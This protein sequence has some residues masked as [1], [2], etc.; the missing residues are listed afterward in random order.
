MRA[1]GYARISDEERA[2]EGY[3]M[4]S[5]H[6][7]ITAYCQAHG[8]ELT[9]IY[10]DGKS[11]KAVAG[12]DGLAALIEDAG[13]G[14]IDRVIVWKLDR[15]GRNLRD[16]LEI[17]DRLEASG[18]GL[19]SI[20][21]SIDTGTAA[22]RMMR[23]MLGVIAEFERDTIVDRIKA[24]LEQKARQ[25][26][27]LGH[28]PLGYQRN[29]AGAVVLDPAAA[30]L[31]RALFERY[32]IG[33]HSLRDLV[34]WCAS[35][36]LRSIFGNPL[37]RLAINKI[38]RNVAYTGQITY[39]ARS[40]GGVIGKGKHEA[41]VDA[42]LFAE[43]QA[44][45]SSRRIHDGGP[46][47]YGK[48]PYPL[49]GVLFCGSCGGRYLGTATTKEGRW[50]YRYMRCTTAQRQGRDAC[51]ESMVV[52]DV[53]EEQ[54]RSYVAGMRL[55]AEDLGL[56][57]AELRRRRQ[58]PESSPAEA[59]A[60][61]R[62]LKRWQR[63]FALGEIEE[64][65]YRKEAG[66]IRRRLAELEKPAGVLDVEKAVNLLRSIHTLWKEDTRQGQ[67]DFV[68]QVF[69][70]ITVRDQRIR[71]I[72]PKPQYAELFA[73]DRVR[74]FDGQ[75]VMW[76]PRQVSGQHNYKPLSNRDIVPDLILPAGSE[77]LLAL[78]R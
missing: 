57:V 60:L 66:S 65:D 12:R 53:L 8:W 76:L 26:E 63:L 28:L 13:S 51:G 18:V 3:G 44:M 31:V 45:L 10:T 17:C 36:G 5:Q 64:T 70:R 38:L 47:P 25:G 11:G 22:G 49:S 54:V 29:E 42:S 73:L 1:C 20:Q 39:K 23:N 61:Q 9:Q 33:A 68:R 34:G 50:R 77:H 4:G 71:Q 40:G 7:S 55:E 62:E 46:R 24:G 43:A 58:R 32:A 30:P 14:A 69:Q 78:A 19:V 35:I 48:E 41:I 75:F 52:A 2:R 56:V 27:L 15:L 16:L 74:R 59:P 6:H 37:D 72:T 67:R 21:E